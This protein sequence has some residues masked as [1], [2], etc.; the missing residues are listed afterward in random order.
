[1]R[2]LI[3]IF[4]FAG[5]AVSVGPSFESLDMRGILLAAAASLA[6]ALQFFSG[7]AIAA[8]MQPAA[9]GSLVHLVI[10]PATLLIALVAGGGKIG[11]FPGGAAT[12]AGLWFLLGV[13]IL[14]VGGYFVHMQSLR[15]APASTVAPFFNLEPM[16]ATAVAALFLGER[17]ATNQ[18]AGGGMVLAAL[19]ASSFI[20]SAKKKA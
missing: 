17:L 4:A 1:M 14:Y 6:C 3:A 20:G 18:Y 5:L 2:I 19:A 13:G 12:S 10:L 9:F 7:R 15:F 8:H 11:F 16:I